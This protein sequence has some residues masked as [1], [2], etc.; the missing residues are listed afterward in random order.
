MKPYSKSVVDDACGSG[1]FGSAADR[2]GADLLHSRREVG[3][4]VEQAV[5]GVDEAVEG[6]V[7]RGPFL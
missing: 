5:G 3:D 1:G 4:E 6:R 2:P 7:R